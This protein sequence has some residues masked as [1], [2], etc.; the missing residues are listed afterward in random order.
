MRL[1]A[2]IR[3]RRRDAGYSQEGFADRVGVHRTF[4]STV[5]RGLSNLS[6]DNIERIAR[7]LGVPAGQLLLEADGLEL[8][9]LG[10]ESSA[11]S[12]F[13]RGPKADP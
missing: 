1:G 10:G 9:G 7:A 4:M 3:R 6:L 5:E 8:P 12:Q 2:V 13:G 11:A